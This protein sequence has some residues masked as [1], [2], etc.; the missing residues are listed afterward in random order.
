MDADDTVQR[1]GIQKRGDRELRCLKC[2][3]EILLVTMNKPPESHVTVGSALLLP[4]GHIFAALRPFLC[5]GRDSH[6]GNPRLSVCVEET[7][8][9]PQMEEPKSSLKDSSVKTYIYLFS[10]YSSLTGYF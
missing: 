10:E 6:Q 8:S 4:A 5:E 3:Q 7:H 2:Q 9:F 1:L